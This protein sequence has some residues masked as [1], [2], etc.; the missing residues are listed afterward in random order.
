MVYSIKTKLH[1][2]YVNPN[3]VKIE[4]TLNC[5][6]DAYLT[7]DTVSKLLKQPVTKMSVGVTLAVAIVVLGS[8]AKVTDNIL[9]NVWPDFSL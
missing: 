9:Y 2:I 3:N 8:G 1:S 5:F 4:K 6:H 7:Q